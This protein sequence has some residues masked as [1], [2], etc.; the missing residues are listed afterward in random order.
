MNVFSELP[1]WL[2]LWLILGTAV[3]VAT[4]LSWK[5]K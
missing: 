2:H 4:L 3:L 1:W 5:R